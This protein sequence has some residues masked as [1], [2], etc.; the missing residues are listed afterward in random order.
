MWDWLLKP[1]VWISAGAI[2]TIIGGVMSALQSEKFQHALQGNIIGGDSYCY[3]L[4]LIDESEYLQ[5][6]VQHVGEYPMYDVTVVIKDITLRAKIFELVGIVNKEMT[7]EEWDKL[8]K[9]NF[10]GKLFEADSKSEIL[11][12]KWP[13][14][15]KGALV[16]SI[17]RMKLPADKTELRFLAKIYARNVTITQPIRFLKING[18]WKEST[19]VQKFDN[20][21]HRCIELKCE[22]DPEVPLEE[23]YAGE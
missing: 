11:R 16:M 12:N 22:L 18:K 3:I 17:Y 13:T 10:I 6:A 14:L 9:D 23:G 20:E 19:R 21:A 1:Y 2:L 8:K 15:P 5:F 4:R 7:N